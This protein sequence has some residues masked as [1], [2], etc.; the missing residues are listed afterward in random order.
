VLLLGTLAF[1]VFTLATAF[2]GTVAELLAVRFVAGLGL[3][4]IMPNATALVGEYSPA[5]RRIA[6]MMIVTNGFMVGAVLGGFVSA[7]L[8]PAHGWRSV[9]LVGGIAPLAVLL[10][11]LLWLPESLQFLTVRGA[12]RERIARW[13]ARLDP[14]AAADGVEFVAPERGPRGIP[15]LQLVREGRAAG[16]ALLWAVSFLNVLN[17]YFVASWLPTAVRDSGYSTS[18]A[19]LV[20]TAV[21][22]GGM[23]GTFVLGGLSRRIGIFP[24]LTACFGVAAVCLVSVV[25]PGLPLPM[26]A[27]T[28][29]ALGWGIFG[30]QPGLN[31]LAATYYPTALRSTGIG[32]AL[33][34]G[35]LGAI[36]GPLIASA[37]MLRHWSNEQLFR[38]AA[39]PAVLSTG[40]VLV[41]RRVMRGQG[42]PGS[43]APSS[44]DPA[45]GAGAS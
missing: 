1:A 22:V 2:A 38:A 37:L 9:F 19:V 45:P 11:M 39:L 30:G 4:A 29:F 10:A 36:F 42:A 40:V 15:L 21:Q 7:W 18:T 35:R 31:A 20:G 12:R 6:T 23:V 27:A 13:A 28:A 3:G 5:R 33:G 43:I 32:A 14:A 8:I 24:L 34:V 44:R 41:M 17:A 26:L 25:H 16:T